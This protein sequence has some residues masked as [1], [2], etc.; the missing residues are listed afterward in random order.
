[1]DS[2]LSQNIEIGKLNLLCIQHTIPTKIFFFIVFS[3]TISTVFSQAFIEK[4]GAAEA[5]ETGDGN[6]L[7]VAITSD[8]GLC[9]AVHTNV[10]KAIRNELS[11][12]TP[13]NAQTKVF[14][15]GDKSRALLQR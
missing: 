6:K 7:I 8:R 11:L 1:M 9:G 10:S 5:P 13:E 15:V 3:S 12:E 2:K 4:S 14:C